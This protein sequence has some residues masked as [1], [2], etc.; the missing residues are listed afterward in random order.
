MRALVAESK[1]LATATSNAASI[2]REFLTDEQRYFEAVDRIKEAVRL[3]G[4][5][6]DVAARGPGLRLSTPTCRPLKGLRLRPAP[7][8]TWPGS[9]GAVAGLNLPNPFDSSIADEFIASMDA[10]S[11]G[12]ES[13]AA[14][15]D[16]QWFATAQ[17]AGGGP[18]RQ[19]GPG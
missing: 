13:A 15:L 1:A 9:L 10:M 5:A 7:Q 3:G 8:T 14:S 2:T 12:A 4:L 16:A 6:E 17:A 19:C 18:A 11:I